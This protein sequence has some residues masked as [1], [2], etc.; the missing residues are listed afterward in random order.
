MQKVILINSQYLGRGD[1]SLG[2]KLMGN[3]LRKLWAQESK[4]KTVVFYNSGVKLLAEGSAALDA[5]D[6]LY[7]DGVDLIVCGT[8][9]AHF[10][11]KERLEIGRISDMTEIASVLTTAD[12]V[13]TV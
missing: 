2:E 3:F 6:G 5:L 13:L 12:G 10:G 9:I 1:D 7:K 8:C 11:L 4:P